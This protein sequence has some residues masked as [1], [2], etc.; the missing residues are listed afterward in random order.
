MTPATRVRLLIAPTIIAMLVFMV[1]PMVLTGLYSIMTSGPYGGVQ[2]PLS[3]EGYLQILFQRDF[4]DTLTFTPAFLWIMLRSV[5]LAGLT[6]VISL[7]VGL[8]VAWFIVCQTPARRA[9]LLFLTTLPFWVNTLIRT[10]CW[11]MILRD[12]G[13]L[14]QGLSALH[15]VSRPIPFMYNDAAI[16]IG[17]V[18]TF[19]PF[20]ILPIYAG[21]ERISPSIVEASHD[22]YASRW[23][24]FLRV[25]WPVGRP[26]AISGA[27]LVF[28][29]ALGS[30]LAPDLLG[31]AKR[32]LIGSLI[33]LQFTSGRDW[34]FGAA[35]ATLVTVGVLLGLVV[36][37]NRGLR[38]A[39]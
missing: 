10:Y 29:P 16:L 31:G 21:L 8:P 14:N 35:L 19:L 11:V 9:L 12:Q 39:S 34:P 38:L 4:D 18:Y 32:L 22:L 3:G 7:A 15:L 28:T 13:L 6:A 20:M 26:G 24:T 33:Q 36:V 5:L 17:M 27:L 25:V 23:Q 37:V 2:W 1:L 30:F